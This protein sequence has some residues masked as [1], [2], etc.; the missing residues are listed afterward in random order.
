MTMSHG[1]AAPV[2]HRITGATKGSAPVQ[3]SSEVLLK[4]LKFYS[5]DVILPADFSQDRLRMNRQLIELTIERI[6]YGV[7][8]GRCNRYC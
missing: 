5:S 6:G 4:F 1:P 2:I 7:R 8:D 3:P